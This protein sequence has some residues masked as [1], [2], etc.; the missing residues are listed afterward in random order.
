MGKTSKPFRK[1]FNSL[2]DFVDEVSEILNCPITVEDATHHLLAY[3]KHDE[4]TDS[5]RISTIMRRRVPENV[6][7]ILWKNNIIPTL[8]SST[9]PLRIKEISEVGLGNRIAISIRKNDEILGFIWVLDHKQNIDDKDLD[10]LVEASKAAKN[11]LLKIQTKMD[12]KQQDHQEIFR[13]LLT[14]HYADEKKAVSEFEQLGIARP[15]TLSIIIFRFDKYISDSVHKQLIYMMETIQKLNIIF[16]QIEDH[17]FIILAAPKTKEPFIELKDYIDTFIHKMK[18]RFQ[19]NGLHS[20]F[21]G[22]H[23]NLQFVHSSYNEAKAVLELK[24]FFPDELK[25]VFGYDQL[26]LFKYFKTL[27]PIY[28][29]PQP[30]IAL[31]EYDKKNNSELLVTLETHLDHDLNPNETAR[32][33]HIHVNTLNYRLKRIAE[34]AQINFKNYNQKGELY[35]TLK[36]GKFIDKAGSS[37]WR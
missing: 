34:I 29:K 32:H 19:F 21:G 16:Y 8:I 36:L 37:N 23:H 30:I 24:E 10:Y 12:K 31:E 6:I 1:N 15:S 22:I 4:K 20:G 27:A 11:L 14:G 28:Q 2:E 3:S 25:D 9:Q 17:D 26:G 7:N 18:E 33:L 35:L 5:A 13:M